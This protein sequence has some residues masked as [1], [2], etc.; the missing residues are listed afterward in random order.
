MR[1]PIHHLL[2]IFPYL[3]LF[4]H[5][6]NTPTLLSHTVRSSLVRFSCLWRRL[7]PP[8][9]KQLLLLAVNHLPLA[10]G[11][12]ACTVHCLAS[13]A[14]VYMTLSGRVTWIEE[15]SILGSLNLTSL[16]FTIKTTQQDILPLSELNLA[17]F[18]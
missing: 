10:V 14:L 2:L 11:V 4:L 8:A 15:S 9:C 3:F 6:C 17:H 12:V 16:P 7:F 5:L 1:L 18:T 13:A